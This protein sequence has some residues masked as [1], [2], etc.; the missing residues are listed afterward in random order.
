MIRCY[1]DLC[2]R[3]VHR[4]RETL[5][6]VTLMSERSAEPGLALDDADL[7]DQADDDHTEAIESLLLKANTSLEPEAQLPRQPFH[8]C[9]PC[10][11]NF[12]AD[13]LGLRRVRNKR[14]SSN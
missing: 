11:A 14:F 12:C 6:T 3:E 13:P 9:T 7:D 4:T 5:Y 8:F 1:C 10:Y 2:G